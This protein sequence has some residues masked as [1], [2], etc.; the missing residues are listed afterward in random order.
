[1]SPSD[2]NAGWIRLRRW[3][4]SSSITLCSVPFS[5]AASNHFHNRSNLSDRFL[6]ELRSDIVV[7][8]IELRLFGGQNNLAR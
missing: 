3:S 5:D 6:A 8:C 4:M 7:N 2:S 1:M